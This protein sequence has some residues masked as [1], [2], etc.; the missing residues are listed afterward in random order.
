MKSA[1]VDEPLTEFF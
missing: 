1:N